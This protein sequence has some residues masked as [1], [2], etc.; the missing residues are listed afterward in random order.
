MTNYERIRIM[1]TTG[2]AARLL[3]VHITTVQRW[4]D[5]GKVKSYRIG[6]RGERMLRRQDLD[7]ILAK[8]NQPQPQV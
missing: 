3:N 7:H 6:P 8:N 1:L 4:C 2:Q 5:C